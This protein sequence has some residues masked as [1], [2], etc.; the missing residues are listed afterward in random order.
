MFGCTTATNLFFQEHSSCFSFV[1]MPLLYFF[2]SRELRDWNSFTLTARMRCDFD[3][4]MCST[5]GN[6]IALKTSASFTNAK[7][8]YPCWDIALTFGGRHMRDHFHRQ[9]DCASEFNLLSEN[10][11]LLEGF[12]ILCKEQKVFAFLNTALLQQAERPLNH[13][14][15]QHDSH[16]LFIL[17]QLSLNLRSRYHGTVVLGCHKSK[18]GYHGIWDHNTASPADLHSCL[19]SFFLLHSLEWSSCF[20]HICISCCSL[21]WKIFETKGVFCHCSS[22]FCS[23]TEHS[24]FPHCIQEHFVKVLLRSVS[25]KTKT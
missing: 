11:K 21:C 23:R 16:S 15:V 19:L 18:N 6:K 3:T 1:L 13:V 20:F 8:V 10:V 5:Y 24:Y 9:D 2:L 12:W 14:D 4:I 25:N 7:K 17:K 22:C